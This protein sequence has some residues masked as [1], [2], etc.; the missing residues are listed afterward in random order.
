[1]HTSSYLRMSWFISQYLNDKSKKYSVL[2]CGSY[3]VNGSY[4]P[5]FPA[6]HFS[7]HGLDLAPGPNVDIVVKNPY[8][9]TSLADNTYDAVISGSAFEHIEFFWVTFAEIVRVLKPE[10]FVCI[11]APR[12]WSRHRYPVDCYR[13]DEDGMM[14]LARYGNL[15]PLHI[16][17]NMKPPKADSAW[18][19]R[20]GDS[21]LVAKKP[22]N[23]KGLV[24]P[25]E[26]IFLESDINSLHTGFI[27]QK[28]WAARLSRV[29]F[30]RTILSW[31][32]L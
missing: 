24:N 11:I 25:K 10:G 19:N 29:K 12:F 30:C 7:Y 28:K 8:Y 13:F 9:W 4:R 5:L 26:Y 22:K 27:T 31:F 21:L 32:R 18:F 1:M 20:G 15:E 17:M 6:E 23:W 3:D 14:A 16:S 2:D